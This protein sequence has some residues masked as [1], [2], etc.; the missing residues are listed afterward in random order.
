[1]WCCCGMCVIM[2]GWGIGIVFRCMKVIMM[3]VVGGMG[4]VFCVSVCERRSTRSTSARR[5]CIFCIWIFSSYLS[6]NMC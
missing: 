5:S 1:M 4:C 2:I 6:V 3:C